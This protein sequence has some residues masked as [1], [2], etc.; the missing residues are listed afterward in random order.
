MCKF[1]VSGNNLVVEGHTLEF[2]IGRK[3]DET[4]VEKI[5]PK[6]LL[7]RGVPIECFFEVLEL[8]KTEY[9]GVEDDETDACYHKVKR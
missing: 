2:K 1:F 4:I 5:Q 3:F 9:A 8:V 6:L 7:V